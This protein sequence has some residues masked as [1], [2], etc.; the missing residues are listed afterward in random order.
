MARQL[1]LV[2]ALLLSASFLA[3]ASEAESE[4]VVN[5]G[6]DFDEKVG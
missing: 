6:T 5:L 2:A 1:V 4:H 3:T